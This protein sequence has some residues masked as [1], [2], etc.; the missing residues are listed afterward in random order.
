[1][2]QLERQKLWHK[3]SNKDK[4]SQAHIMKML[5]KFPKISIFAEFHFTKRIAKIISS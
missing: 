3:F 4:P 2:G 5:L 1:M